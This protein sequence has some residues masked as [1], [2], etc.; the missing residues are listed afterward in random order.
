[1]PEAHAELGYIPIKANSFQTYHVTAIV[2]TEAQTC[3][4]GLE[5]QK[6]LKY[7]DEYIVLLNS[8][9][10]R[11]TTGYMFA[12]IRVGSRETHQAIYVSENLSGFYLSESGLKNL[13]LLPPDFL[14]LTSQRNMATS[15]EGKLHADAPGEL[16]SHP[17]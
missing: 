7:S 6:A 3:S 8:G 16:P 17:H 11:K 5:I 13:G 12:H 4:C 15:N 14:T 9:D 10:H 1:M 2:K